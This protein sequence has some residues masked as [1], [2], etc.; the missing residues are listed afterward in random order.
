MS[1]PGHVMN[2]R[3]AFPWLALAAV[4]GATALPASA[5]A[6]PCLDLAACLADCAD[7]TCQR[8]CMAAADAETQ[9]LLHVLVDCNAANC[10]PGSPSGCQ[11]RYCHAELLACRN[12][13][14]P[15]PGLEQPGGEEQPPS[16]MAGL[17]FQFGF[18]YASVIDPNYD[19]AE[20]RG[21]L[22]DAFLLAPGLGW[23]GNWLA[24][25]ATSAPV[26][27]AGVGLDVGLR[28]D[29]D[30]D[31]DV[32]PA[33][34]FYF[35]YFFANDL[36]DDIWTFFGLGARLEAGWNDEDGKPFFAP[37]GIVAFR[38]LGA[39]TMHVEGFVG[40]EMWFPDNADVDIGV[41]AG[42]RV[43]VGFQFDA[44]APRQRPTRP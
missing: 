33:G 16:V 9:D 1:R 22:V 24:G 10:P 44:S 38:W 7:A 27:N 2:H 5:P 41:V 25:P 23:D 4:A 36:T 13:G 26:F 35:H 42:L 34:Y 18:A 17:M 15:E 8:S 37:Q 29:G 12:S 39:F 3:K 11:S 14:A 6:S 31:V 43:A 40:P 21:A 28:F 32:T 30:G 20:S 19:Y